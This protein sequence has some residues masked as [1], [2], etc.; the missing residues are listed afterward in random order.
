MNGRLW[1]DNEVGLLT[2][3]AWDC[4]RY[5]ERHRVAEGHAELEVCWR[6]VGRRAHEDRVARRLAEF[7]ACAVR[8]PGSTW[9]GCYPGGPVNWETG[10]MTGV[11]S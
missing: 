9:L 4:G 5:F 3:I 2:D 7:A 11:L 6:P 10:A 8:Q 1:T